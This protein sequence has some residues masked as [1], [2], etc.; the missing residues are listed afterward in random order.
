MVTTRF[1][2]AGTRILS[3]SGPSAVI[4]INSASSITGETGARGGA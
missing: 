3:V 1:G 2:T 4:A